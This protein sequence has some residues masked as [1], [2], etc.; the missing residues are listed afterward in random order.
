[1]TPHPPDLAERIREA[2]PQELFYV[3]KHGVKFTGMPAWPAIQ[4]EDEV[5]AVVAF[6]RKLAHLDQTGYRQ[7]VDGEFAAT[8]PIYMLGVLPA[9]PAAVTQNCARCHGADGIGRGTGRF[10]SSRDSEAHTSRMRS[11]PIPGVSGT[12]VSWSQ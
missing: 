6:L 4:R 9:V 5:W 2:K 3:V 12:A 1:M 8:P 7:L 11:M 10:R